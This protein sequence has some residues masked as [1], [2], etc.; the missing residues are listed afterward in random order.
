[1]TADERALELMGRLYPI[2]GGPHAYER[3]VD[4]IADAIRQA[5][6]E[7]IDRAAD[8]CEKAWRRG[9]SAAVARNDI[10]TLK[11]PPG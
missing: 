7:A 4:M 3:A 9:E 8:L 10:L 6:N 1:M 5:V 2:P 11:E